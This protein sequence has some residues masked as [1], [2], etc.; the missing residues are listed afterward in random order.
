MKKIDMVWVSGIVLG[1][2]FIFVVNNASGFE[3]SYSIAG[4]N[5]TGYNGVASIN[6]T[7]YDAS[8]GGNNL[9]TNT[10]DTTIEGN[11]FTMSVDNLALSNYNTTLYVEVVINDTSF[12]RYQYTP[13][14]Q[15]MYCDMLDGYHASSLL[16]NEDNQTLSWDSGTDQ[17]TISGGNTIDIS[18]V[19]T[20]TEYSENDKYLTLTVTTF[21]VDE[22]NLNNTIIAITDERDTDTILSGADV[23]AFVGNWST[24]KS[25]YNTSAEMYSAL[26][27]QDEC[28]E[29]NGCVTG[30]ITSYQDS[31][32]ST[33]CS[34]DTTYLSGDGN[35]NDISSVYQPLEATLTDIADGTINENL[36]NTANPWADNEVSDTL[37]CSILIDDDT[38]ATT[39]SAETFD[40]DVTFAK[41]ITYN[42]GGTANFRIW[43]DAGGNLIIGPR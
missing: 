24:D 8:T 35:C 30:A 36:V 26:A 20:N 17:I 12:G 13:A 10:S 4:L 28:S 27:T 15:S 42:A 21:G 6:T 5:V 32:A 39:G 33:I 40:E 7:F 9:F 16:D 19:D 14:I 18:S 2:L 31:N 25:S 29:I 34:G 37:T 43:E 23:V 38:Y 1:L 3:Y 41:N 22:S 11:F